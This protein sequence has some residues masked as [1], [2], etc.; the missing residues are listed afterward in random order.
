MLDFKHNQE[1]NFLQD[2]KNFI[3]K[4]CQIDNQYSKVSALSIVMAPRSPVLALIG[5]AELSLTFS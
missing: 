3:Q 5:I 2:I 1:L 4:K